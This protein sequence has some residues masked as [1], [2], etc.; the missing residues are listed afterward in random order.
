ML[1]GMSYKQQLTSQKGAGERSHQI[2][3]IMETQ[4]IEILWIG[5]V[6]P[7]PVLAIGDTVQVP[8]SGQQGLVP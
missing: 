4:T 2:K 5:L 8:G 7:P 6:K 3:S 1:K